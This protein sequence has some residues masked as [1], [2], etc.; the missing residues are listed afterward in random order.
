MDKSFQ[1]ELI[2]FEEYTNRFEEIKNDCPQEVYFTEIILPFL[3][4]CCPEGVK[5]VPIF[6]DRRT[7]P[8]TTNKSHANTRMDFI[9]AKNEENAKGGYI[10]PDFIFVPQ[11]YSYA[12]PC[13][14]YMMVETKLPYVFVEK[15]QEYKYIGLQSHINKKPI[16][17]LAETRA[18]G[19]V[20]ITD[21]IAWGY[22]VEDNNKIKLEKESIEL[23]HPETL[24][25]NEK[26]WEIL[27]EYLQGILKKKMEEVPE[28]QK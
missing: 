11:K 21:G 28:E 15:K 5:V 22:C 13:K 23:A 1:R 18:C 27:K 14:P 9:C 6:A 19:G 20:I 16:E 24:E 25:K 2:S 7:G 3:R 26:A 17:L 12:K 10:V 4:M 8:K